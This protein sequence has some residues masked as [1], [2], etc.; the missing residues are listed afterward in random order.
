M[1]SAITGQ[2]QQENSQRCLH[3]VERGDLLELE[4]QHVPAVLTLASNGPAQWTASFGVAQPYLLELPSAGRLVISRQGVASGGG[5]VALE[6]VHVG[7]PLPPGDPLCFPNDPSRSPMMQRSQQFLPGWPERSP[8]A[9]R[10]HRRI[11]GC[12][13]RRS[14]SPSPL[15][16]AGAEDS[17]A[18]QHDGSGDTRTRLIQQVKAR[19]KASK[20]VNKRWRDFCQKEGGG[21]FDPNR[22]DA[23]FLED[24]LERENR[25][26]K[27]PGQ[28]ERS[29]SRGPGGRRSPED[30]S[31]S[32]PRGRWRGVGSRSPSSPRRPVRKRRCRSTK[33]KRRLGH[34]RDRRR[35]KEKRRRHDEDAA[36]RGRTRD[37]KRKKRVAKAMKA[38]ARDKV[39]HSQSGRSTAASESSGRDSSAQSSELVAPRAAGGAG[40]VQERPEL[41]AARNA[42]QS[43][44]SRQAEVERALAEE[45]QALAAQVDARVRAEEERQRV[46]V[47][48]FVQEVEREA[49]WEEEERV[50]EA[51]R[52][53]REARE[54][55]VEST[56]RAVEEEAREVVATVERRARE[57]VANRLLGAEARSR[58]AAAEVERSQVTLDSL[59]AEEQQPQRRRLAAAAAAAAEATEDGN[60]AQ[61]GAGKR[62]QKAHMTAPRAAKRRS[63]KH[64]TAM[65]SSGASASGSGSSS[66]SSTEGKCSQASSIDSGFDRR[67]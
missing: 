36:G 31:V 34:G 4:A 66:E 55:K 48:R 25:L 59:L 38:A 65:P 39:S 30:A 20:E 40:P 62:K 18:G 63:N 56:R 13:G 58:D 32:C 11:N 1:V 22:H 67:P 17:G 61:R 51:V 21:I 27:F 54:A 35:E 42:L 53:A 10:C 3:I 15:A 33:R 5:E 7:D 47:A 46:E 37:R 28:Q 45:Q 50:Q 8:S 49:R 64:Q 19:Q 23:G 60:A 9:G 12:V 26:S 57:D 14:R 16:G 43:A 6:F 2:W 29:R 44:R 52:A 41:I 24:F